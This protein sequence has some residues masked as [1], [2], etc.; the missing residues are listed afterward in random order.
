MFTQSFST[1]SRGKTRDGYEVTCPD[2]SKFVAYVEIKQPTPGELTARDVRS[3]TT[4]KDGHLVYLGRQ[5]DYGESESARLLFGCDAYRLLVR[6]EE[7][8]FKRGAK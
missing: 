7:L 4:D 2:G 6:V 8:L 1:R 5:S 3:Y